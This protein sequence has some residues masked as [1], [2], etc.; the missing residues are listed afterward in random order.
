MQADSIVVRDIAYRGFRSAAEFGAGVLTG[1]ALS[2]DA[3]VLAAPAGARDDTDPHTGRTA[4]YEFGAWTAPVVS[5]GFTASE[6][7]P[8]WTADTPPGCWLHIELRGSTAD[9]RDTPWFTLA[10]WTAGDG[11]V[12]RTSVPGQSGPAGAVAADVLVAGPG[13]ALTAWQL[14]VTLLRA[15]GSAATPVLRSAGAVA[16]G[17]PRPDAALPSAPETAHG[18]VL[19]VP[20]YSQKLHIGHHPRWAGGGHGWCSP[21]STA[22]VLR[23]WGV[24]PTPADHAW[25][26]A[27]HTDPDVDHAAR[28]CY[29]HAYGGT[30]NWPFNTAYAGRYG[31]DGFVTRLRSLVE[32]ERF[33]A[34]GI[35][36]IV[37]ASYVRGEIPGLDYDTAGH[38]MVLVGFTA[39]GEP[40]LNDPAAPSNDRVRTPVPR[41]E[42]ERAWLGSSRGLV[43][44]IRPP[45]VPLPPPGSQPNW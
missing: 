44:V 33:I 12:A 42:F 41:A 34:A 29:D 31:L 1:V 26:G 15:A 8:S 37:S 27:D 24:G 18:V 30:G 19:D 3:V 10:R 45:H 5:P 11:P 39:T 38:L 13:R 22:M 2:G 35:P 23:F 16:T 25:V 36:L 20:P 40:V 43:Y 9:G 32:A 7:I 4:R 17:A 14:R 28:H 21:A 6:V